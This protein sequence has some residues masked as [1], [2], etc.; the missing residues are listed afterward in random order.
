VSDIITLGRDIL[1]T[2]APTTGTRATG[3]VVIRTKGNTPVN[4]GPNWALIPRINNDLREELAFKIAAGPNVAKYRDGIRVKA[5]PADPDCPSWWTIQPGGTLVAVTSIVGGERHN[6]KK[7]TKLYFDPIHPDL[8]VVAEVFEEFTGGQD[9]THF[10]GCKNAV[11]FEQMNA[12]T[13]SLDA[14]RSKLQS[15]P[16]VVVVWDDSEPADGTTQSTLDRGASRGGR[17]ESRFSERFNVFVLASRLDGGHHRS[18]EGLRLLEDITNELIN[19]QEIDGKIFSNPGVQVRGR[20]RIT[21][22][23]TQFQGMYVYLLQISA[24]ATIVPTDRRTFSP[25]LRVHNQILTHDADDAGARK[26]V[27]D[28]QID[29]TTE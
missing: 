14:F 13:A 28:Q 9:P 17:V 15:F 25:W 19:R 2:I 27:V 16:S 18:A 23:T 22:D 26:V 7:G 10:G 4:L 24:T 20:S 11:L 29:M 12:P 3:Q 6:L 21:G 8:E 5:N 1:S